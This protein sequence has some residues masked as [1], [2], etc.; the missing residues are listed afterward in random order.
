MDLHQ[1]VWLIILIPAFFIIGITELNRAKEILINKKISLNLA[2]RIRIWLIKNISGKKE[3]KQYEKKIK[4][5]EKGTQVSG[6]YSA[7]GGLLYMF[8]SIFFAWLLFKA[9]L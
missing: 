4:E 9:I 1:I 6:Y 2:V 3:A 7:I 5:N 8:G